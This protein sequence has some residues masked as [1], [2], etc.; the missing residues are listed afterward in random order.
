MFTAISTG[1]RSS[2]VFTRFSSTPEISR[3]AVILMIFIRLGFRQLSYH[4]RPVHHPLTASN[5]VMLPGV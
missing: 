3:L 2:S 5:K 1:S 4:Q